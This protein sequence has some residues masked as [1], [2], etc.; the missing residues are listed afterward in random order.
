M[1]YL[2]KYI[3]FLCVFYTHAHESAGV[4]TAQKVTWEVKGNLYMILLGKIMNRSF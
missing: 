2:R 4:W 3:P 1:I